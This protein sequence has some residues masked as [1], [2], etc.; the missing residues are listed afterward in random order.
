MRALIL[1]L[2]ITLSGLVFAKDK[3]K[4]ST[5]DCDDPLSPTITEQ[6]DKSQ[7]GDNIFLIGTCSENVVIEKDITIDGGGTAATLNPVT[8]S[9]PT[10][11]VSASNVKIAGLNI[12]AA[13]VGSHVL[14][15][16]M[17]YSIPD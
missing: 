4:T 7:P 14:V 17:S 15:T 16:K 11:V 13:R 3:P 12:T 6:I 1:C 8:D 9:L 5:I 2:T 10:I